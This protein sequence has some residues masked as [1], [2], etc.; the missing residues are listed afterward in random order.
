MGLFSKLVAWTSEQPALFL[1]LR[2]LLENDFRV[3]RA[4]IRRH[5]SGQ[6]GVRTLDLGCG[7]GAFSTL[8]ACDSYVG[9]DINGR[10]IAHARRHFQGRFLAG[11]ARKV[12][13]A[14]ASVDQILVF[15]LLHHL[16]DETVRSVLVEMRRVLAPAGHALVIED[17]PTVSRLN[18]LGHLIHSAE[19]GE[20]IRPVDE[21]RR[22]YGERFALESEEILRSGICDYFAAVL[23]P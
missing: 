5:L 3:I 10:Y 13:L 19:N 20:H 8:F 23:R 14:D 7:P 22:L 18:L 12:E 6:A 9:I 15:G 4:V 2:G 17:I 21:Y 11:D 1:F 16:D